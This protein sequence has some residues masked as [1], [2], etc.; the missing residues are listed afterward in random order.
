[1]AEQDDEFPFSMWPTPV[2]YFVLFEV[3]VFLFEDNVIV[4]ILESVT[5]KFVKD[6]WSQ[7]VD[8]IKP[9]LYRWKTVEKNT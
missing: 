5:I 9:T 1:M 4:Y 8:N 3:N 6:F 2:T 7:N